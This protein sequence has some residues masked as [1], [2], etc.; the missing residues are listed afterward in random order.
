MNVPMNRFKLVLGAA[1]MATA[2]AEV[3]A[4]SVALREFHTGMTFGFGCPAGYFATPA[5]KAEV[6]RMCEDGVPSD[7]VVLFD[8]T[9]DDVNH[10]LEVLSYHDTPAYHAAAEKLLAAWR[11]DTAA[12]QVAADVKSVAGTLRLLKAFGIGVE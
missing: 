6:D 4:T 9:A 2:Q 10:A 11:A 8:G 5:A 7:A 1:L 12:Q 3:L